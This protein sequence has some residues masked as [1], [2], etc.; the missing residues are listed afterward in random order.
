MKFGHVLG[1]VIADT[2]EKESSVKAGADA[3]TKVIKEKL[4]AIS[5]G[6]DPES[7]NEKQIQ[8]Q[9]DDM[10]N[11]VDPDSAKYM[12]DEPPVEAACPQGK[13]MPV[14]QARACEA[15]IAEINGQFAALKAR[16]DALSAQKDRIAMD[17]ANRSAELQS[18]ENR[19]AIDTASK[20]AEL[21]K[22]KAAATEA[23]SKIEACSDNPTT[24]AKKACL[25]H[26][27]DGTSTKYDGYDLD[28]SVVKPDYLGGHK[29]SP[30]IIKSQNQVHDDGAIRKV[31]S[32]KVCVP[33][34]GS[35]CPQAK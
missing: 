29:S 10:D 5:N 33:S 1:H 26:I 11:G 22:K 34:P 15:R 13:V 35:V 25:D 20:M 16:H 21:D 19:I 14:A 4:E 28:P 7:A 30:T 27:F 17:L 31:M 24:M 3:Q 9:M 8:K 2:D 6:V 18:Q 12:R 32:K 23:Q